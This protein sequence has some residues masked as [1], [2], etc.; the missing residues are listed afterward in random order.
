MRNHLLAIMLSVAL[1]GT[2]ISTSFAIYA[3]FIH[4]IDLYNRTTGTA[5]FFVCLGCLWAVLHSFR[6]R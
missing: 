3:V 5:L 4:S 6:K 2:V 1:W